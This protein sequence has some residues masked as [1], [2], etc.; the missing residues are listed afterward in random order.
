[1][2]SMSVFSDLLILE[3]SPNLD[4]RYKSIPCIDS[5]SLMKERDV[6]KHLLCRPQLPIWPIRLVRSD[7]NLY[8]PCDTAMLCLCFPLN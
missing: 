5:N 7:L 3:A 6:A 1:M 4:K 8:I 2:F